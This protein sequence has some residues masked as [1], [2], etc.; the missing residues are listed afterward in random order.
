MYFFIYLN[1]HW[2]FTHTYI[3]NLFYFIKNI[4]TYHNN[5][6]MITTTKG[7]TYLI[8]VCMFAF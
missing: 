1:A 8:D 6:Y 4:M 5:I 2:A 3:Y 7:I